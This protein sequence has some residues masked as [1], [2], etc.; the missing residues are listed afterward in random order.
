MTETELVKEG[1]KVEFI[2]QLLNGGRIQVV[3]LTVL[4]EEP[5]KS[6]EF[7]KEDDSRSTRRRSSS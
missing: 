7:F 3:K 2:A 6:E 1:D 4:L 5:L